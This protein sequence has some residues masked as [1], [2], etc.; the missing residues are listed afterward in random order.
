MRGLLSGQVVR[1]RALSKNWTVL[2][3]ELVRDTNGNGQPDVAILRSRPVD[4]SDGGQFQ[5]QFVIFDTGPAFSQLRL[6]GVEQFF[7]PIQM[8]NIGD[9]NGNGTDELAIYGRHLNNT[10][11]KAQVFD[12][13]RT[14]SRL[15]TVFFDRNFVG[16]DFD[17]CPDL[18]G[19]GSPELVLFGKRASDG[20]L[21]AIVKDARTGQLVGKVDFDFAA[22]R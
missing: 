2:K 16:E 20:K 4:G 5:N 12:S 15:S 3:Q 8:L 14:T 18:N 17:A 6:R 9:I 10:S 1:D 19:N 22:Y 7:E 21:R 13:G 11:Q